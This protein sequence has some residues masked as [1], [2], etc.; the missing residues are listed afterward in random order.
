MRIGVIGTGYVGLVAGVC[1]ADTG[2][3]VTCVD[4]DPE[5]VLAL[6]RG[7]VPI[8]E[9]GLAAVLRRVQREHRITFTTNHSEAIQGADVVFL[10]VG[11]PEGED[12]S[13]DMS[14]FHSATQGVP[15]GR[16]RA[17][18]SSS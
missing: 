9:P 8:Y 14:S 7:E 6:Q 5:K 4:N 2:N 17:A 11:T 13:P 3:H 18:A 1:F 10:A 15:S 12:G 16:R